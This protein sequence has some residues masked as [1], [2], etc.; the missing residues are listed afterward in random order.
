M[1][2]KVLQNELIYFLL[3]VCK[4]TENVESHTFITLF[5]KDYHKIH[6]LIIYYNIINK[7]F[8]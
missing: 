2:D 7:A 6:F 3:P 5:N 8:K 1:L 4:Q